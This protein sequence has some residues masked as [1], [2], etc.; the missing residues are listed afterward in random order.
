MP[1]HGTSLQILYADG[2]FSE[3]NAERPLP[4]EVAGTISPQLGALKEVHNEKG[5]CYYNRAHFLAL[6]RAL[7]TIVEAADTEVYASP[8]DRNGIEMIGSTSP[9]R[10]L[11]GEI[12]SS[13]VFHSSFDEPSC[14][15]GTVCFCFG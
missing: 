14:R 13:W 11:V 7:G 1:Y 2:F 4:Q 9:Q 15:F 12:K 3:L 5:V 10:Y 8:A 6:N